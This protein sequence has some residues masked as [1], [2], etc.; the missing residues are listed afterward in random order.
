[1]EH[2]QGHIV[3]YN[4]NLDSLALDRVCAFFLKMS[5][6]PRERRNDSG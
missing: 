2:A 4:F 5:D 6:Q 3:N 1:M